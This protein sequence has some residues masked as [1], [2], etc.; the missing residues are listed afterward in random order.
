[1][2]TVAAHTEALRELGGGSGDILDAYLAMA[3]ATARRAGSRGLL[4]PEQ[5][6]GIRKAL[7]GPGTDG[8][9]P[10]EGP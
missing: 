3:R 2:G 1:V 8:P 6:D 7:E 9:H 4:R 5:I 10:E